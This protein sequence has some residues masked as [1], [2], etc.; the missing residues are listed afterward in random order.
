M[1]VKRFFF[2][3]IL[4]VC[5]ANLISC[6][7]QTTSLLADESLVKVAL[8]EVGNQL[9]LKKGD[10]TSRVLPV[11]KVS[12]NSY[13]LQFEKH[14]AFDPEDLYTASE[15]VL[16]KASL[17]NDYLLEVTACNATVVVYSYQV[18][19]NIETSIIPC[20]GRILPKDC[21]K[22]YFRFNETQSSYYTNE[23]LFWVLVVLVMFFLVFVFISRFFTT[24]HHDHDHEFHL[25]IFTFFPDQLKLVKEAEEIQ[26]SNKE[27]ELLSILIE[28]PNEVVK[29]EELTK[30]VWEDQGV[31]VGRSLDTYI[32]KLR[33]KLQADA[34]IKITNIH[35]VGYKLEI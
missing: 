31:V 27:V 24:E 9:L 15:M 3:L 7:K 5:I 14:I 35:G 26:L 10:S 29:R 23:I 25:G 20:G 2:I 34:N 33:K 30:R 6:N 16:N 8:R 4:T 17:P 19:Q 22:I 28:S 1:I 32:S 13:L 11:I 12:T 18:Q 21:Y